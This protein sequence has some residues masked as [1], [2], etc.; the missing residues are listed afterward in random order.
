MLRNVP[1][2]AAPYIEPHQQGM[3]RKKAAVRDR[4]LVALRE[5]L[6]RVNKGRSGRTTTG[7]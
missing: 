6:F 7:G 4:S 5:S 1:F 2:F 3:Q